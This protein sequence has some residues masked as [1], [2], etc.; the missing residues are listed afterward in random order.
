LPINLLTHVAIQAVDTENM[1]FHITYHIL[2][3]QMILTFLYKFISDVKF[4]ID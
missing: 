4:E 1:C 3:S 2:N